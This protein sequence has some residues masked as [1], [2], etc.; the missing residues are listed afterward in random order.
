MHQHGTSRTIGCQL[1]VASVALGLA[2]CLPSESAIRAR[3]ERIEAEAEQ[4]GST[5]PWAGTYYRG[6]GLGRNEL[7]TLAPVEGFQYS[8]HGCLGL[9]GA[10]S[11]TVAE[12]D[13]HLA[14][15]GFLGFPSGGTP[16]LVVVDWGKRRY[17]LEPE[18][19]L[20]FVNAANQHV[21]AEEELGPGLLQDRQFYLRLTDQ[22]L[23]LVGAPSLPTEF[24]KL[25]RTSRIT[26]HVLTVRGDLVALDIG[27]EHGVFQGM[28]L[29]LLSE[30]P[31]GFGRAV[32]TEV[33]EDSSRGSVEYMDS[34]SPPVAPGWEAA[35]RIFP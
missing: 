4:L 34:H 7:L 16:T 22:G 23:P 2:A 24:A 27:L 15:T 8:N 29:Y 14:L 26:G 3:R 32:V 9:Y 11:G 19:L 31:S 25:L 6:D 20:S 17:L 21:G 1:L 30:H 33:H 5:H 13:G 28:E 18:Q 12:R 35:S 10:S